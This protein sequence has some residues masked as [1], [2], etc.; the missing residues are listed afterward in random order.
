MLIGSPKKL[1]W[2]WHSRAKMRYYG[3]SEARVRRVMHAPA[4]TEEGIA[5]GTT[6]MMQPIGNGR[7]ELWIMIVDSPRLRKVISAWRYPGRTKPRSD[8]ALGVMR[9]QYEEYVSSLTEK[10]QGMGAKMKKNK[11]FRR[12]IR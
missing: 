1:H 6:A 3:L 5:P 9:A 11:W 12:K 2:T 10:R 7:H 4:R 8:N